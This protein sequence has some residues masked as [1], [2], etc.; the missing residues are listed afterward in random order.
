MN[1]EKLAEIIDRALQA[2]D[3]DTSGPVARDDGT[4]GIAVH[5]F[6][7]PVM[8]VVIGGGS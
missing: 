3:F 4:T 2:E 8:L 5:R 7:S 6:D 1:H